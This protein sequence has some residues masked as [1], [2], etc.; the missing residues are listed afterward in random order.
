MVNPLLRQ[1]YLIRKVRMNPILTIALKKHHQLFLCLQNISP[2]VASRH[3]HHVIL[4]NNIT[5]KITY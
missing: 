1:N 4:L 5:N 2:P 3:N